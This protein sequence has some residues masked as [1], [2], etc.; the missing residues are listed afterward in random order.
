MLSVSNHEGF[1]NSDLWLNVQEKLAG[2]KQLS[3]SQA[4]KYSWLTG[5][6]KCAD[7]GYSIKINYNKNDMKFYLICSGKSNLRICDARISLSIRE[8]EKSIEEKLTEIISECNS[9]NINNISDDNLYKVYDIDCKIERLVTALSESNNIAISYINKQI[10][11]L[12][13]EREKL[14]T[15]TKVPKTK[16][17]RIDFTNAS[18]DEKKI[19]AAQFI[20]KILLSRDTAEVIWKI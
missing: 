19:I 5:L 1:I 11:H 17:A 18:F 12:H 8:L 7:C 9:E 15:Q 14:L 2:N 10:E 16:T 4:G 13:N 20:D 6:L 3:R